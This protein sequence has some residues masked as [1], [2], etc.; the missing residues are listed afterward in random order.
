MD[1]DAAFHLPPRRLPA[2]FPWPVFLAIVCL[3]DGVSPAFIPLRRVNVP[4]LIVVFHLLPSCCCL[5]R[6]WMEFFACGFVLG[7]GLDQ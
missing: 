2:V 6:G 7:A 1:H 5:P 4:I 3:V